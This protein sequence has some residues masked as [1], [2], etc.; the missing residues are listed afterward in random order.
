[1]NTLF[2]PGLYGPAPGQGVFRSTDYGATWTN[3][4][5]GKFPEAVVWGTPKGLY[6]MY[7]WACSGCNLGTNYETAPASGDTW[8]AAAVPAALTIG[9]NSVAV[10]YDGAHYVFLAV[11][12]DQGI[13]RYVEP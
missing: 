2:M 5:T 3:V 9:P 1:V 4:D 7:G 11:M 6:A 13:W 8:T 12:W 10:A